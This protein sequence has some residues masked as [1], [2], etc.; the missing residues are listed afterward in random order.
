MP[1]ACPGKPT[2]EFLDYTMGRLT[3]AGAIFLTIVAILPAAMSRQMNVPPT[4][5]QFLRGTSVLILVGVLLD[6]MRQ[7]ETHL[8]QRHYDG[9]CARANPRAIE[10]QQTSGKPPAPKRSSCFGPCRDPHDLQ[11]LPTRSTRDS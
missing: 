9:F 7:V 10:R 2:A 11:G 8:I 4:A 3:F 5:A 1:G 6:V